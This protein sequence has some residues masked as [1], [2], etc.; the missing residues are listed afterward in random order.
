MRMSGRELLLHTKGLMRRQLCERTIIS[1][2]DIYTLALQIF[3]N[4][5]ENVQKTPEVQGTLI[6]HIIDAVLQ[7]Y[8]YNLNSVSQKHQL[9]ELME[10]VKTELYCEILRGLA[11]YYQK[12]A[13]NEKFWN[14]C[15]NMICC[16][17][18]GGDAQQLRPVFGSVAVKE[19]VVSQHSHAGFVDV[20]FS[21]VSVVPA[22]ASA[23]ATP[24]SLHDV[25]PGESAHPAGLPIV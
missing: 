20:D 7:D 22:S 16:C 13:E 23:H 5:P 18:R 1:Q 8:Y 2:Q 14:R 24:F 12:M 21:A 11:L 25:R 6:I 3:N 19:A 15:W 4:L 17:K 9:R 10:W